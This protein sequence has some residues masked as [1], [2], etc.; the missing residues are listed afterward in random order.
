MARPSLD[1][2]TARQKLTGT[3]R[4]KLRFGDY[5]ANIPNC[6][7]RTKQERATPF[8]CWPVP[9]F[10]CPPRPVTPGTYDVEQPSSVC[11]LSSAPLSRQRDD[12]AHQGRAH[13]P[14]SSPIPD[15]G[16][17]GTAR[18]AAI[19]RFQPLPRQSAEPF[20]RD[21]SNTMAR[22][23]MEGSRTGRLAS[24]KKLAHYKTFRPRGCTLTRTLDGFQPSKLRLHS[25]FS[26]PPAQ[27]FEPSK[28]RWPHSSIGLATARDRFLLKASL[29]TY[30]N[31]S[32]LIRKLRRS[33]HTALI[34]AR[35]HGERNA[36]DLRRTEEARS[37]SWLYAP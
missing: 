24:S 22:Q 20:R 9:V 28:T 15:R 4:V 33:T 27:L 29:C 10:C 36:R 1:V 3:I 25:C 7:C 30:S 34:R 8:L 11:S 16:Y 31:V 6:P 14:Q 18:K 21:F 17:I 37:C 2:S 35:P 32:L 19:Q 12:P 23:R 5:L 26:C 13:H